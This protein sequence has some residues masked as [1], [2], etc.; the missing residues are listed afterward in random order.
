MTKEEA[1][2]QVLEQAE[3]LFEGQRNWVCLAHLSESHL[4]LL[5][6]TLGRSGKIP[7]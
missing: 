4:T 6:L 5:E 3:S 7:S 2:K 1:Y